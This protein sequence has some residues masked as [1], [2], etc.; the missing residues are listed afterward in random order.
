MTGDA[1]INGRDRMF[2]FI[3]H[4]V[5]IRMADATKENLDLDVVVVRCPTVNLGQ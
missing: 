4:L 1:R 2:P 5:Q 3:P